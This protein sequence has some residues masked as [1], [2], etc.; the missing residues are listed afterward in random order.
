MPLAPPLT[1]PLPPAPVAPPGPVVPA[2]PPVGALP[3]ASLPAGQPG[4]PAGA[5][6]VPGAPGGYAGYVGPTGAPAPRSG[7]GFGAGIGVGTA[8]GCVS[9]ILALILFFSLANLGMAFSIGAVVLPLILGAVLLIW[10]QTRGIGVG[11]L[12][13]SAAAWIIVIGPCLGLLNGL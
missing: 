9:M 11:V 5:P 8:V 1:P 10:R 3:G 2:G 13:I 7:L 6:G 12:I 4:A